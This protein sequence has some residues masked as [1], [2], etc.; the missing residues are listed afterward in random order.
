MDKFILEHLRE[1]S[2]PKTADVFFFEFECV[3]ASDDNV[4][5]GPH[6]WA[7]CGTDSSR[8]TI[9]KDST[10]TLIFA[11]SEDLISSTLLQARVYEALR[12]GAIPVILGEPA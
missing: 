10:F 8:K 2:S 4:N 6:D 1:L 9:L 11:P 5:T 7:L 12:S 3:P